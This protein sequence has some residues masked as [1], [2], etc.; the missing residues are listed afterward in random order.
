MTTKR[1]VVS[2]LSTVVALLTVFVAGATPASAAD[3]STSF[4]VSGNGSIAKGNLVWH[5]RSVQVGGSVNSTWENNGAYVSIYPT[6]SDNTKLSGPYRRFVG[7]Q[8]TT[9]YG[10]T[11]PADVVGGAHY[12]YVDLYVKL[13]SGT[14]YAYQGSDRCTRS[15]CSSY[16]W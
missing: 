9:N 4:Y 16:K 10:F 2:V 13:G 12:V 3:P 15:G 11:M 6:R 8:L 1:L 7:Q 5:N 14:A